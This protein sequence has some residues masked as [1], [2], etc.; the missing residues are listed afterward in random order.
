MSNNPHNFPV[1]PKDGLCP[2]CGYEVPWLGWAIDKGLPMCKFCKE[3][4]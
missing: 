2:E 4:K 3:S 1:I